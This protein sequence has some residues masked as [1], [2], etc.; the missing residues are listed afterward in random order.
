V[1]GRGGSPL[2]F[3]SAAL[4]VSVSADRAFAASEAP[5]GDPPRPGTRA[6]LDPYFSSLLLFC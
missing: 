3:A 6:A 5:L 4:G 1:P 2:G